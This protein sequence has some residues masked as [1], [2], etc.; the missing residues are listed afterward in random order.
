MQTVFLIFLQFYFAVRLNLVWKYC[1]ENDF[2]GGE[3]GSGWVLFP[4][5]DSINF[6]LYSIVKIFTTLS[7]IA[8][9]YLKIILLY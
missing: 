7:K 1:K 9:A 8:L 4:K 2:F 3:G 5:E 6:S